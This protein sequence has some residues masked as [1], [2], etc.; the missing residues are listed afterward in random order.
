M[1]GLVPGRPGGWGVIGF[2]L[3]R[4]RKPTNV[5]NGHND[6]KSEVPRVSGRDRNREPVMELEGFKTLPLHTLLL[7][8]HTSLL[9][10]F[11]LFTLF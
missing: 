3:R 2:I 5:S 9:S 4:V 1:S 6:R 10:P 8:R 11:T 7:L